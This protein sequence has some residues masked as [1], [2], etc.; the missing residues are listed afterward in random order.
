[1]CLSVASAGFFATDTFRGRH[2]FAADSIAIVFLGGGLER[3]HRVTINVRT[4]SNLHGVAPIHHDIPF[5][6]DTQ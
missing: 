3:D 5:I 4:R 2:F 1:V 6:S